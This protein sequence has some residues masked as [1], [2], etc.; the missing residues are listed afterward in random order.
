MPI[1]Y[2]VTYADNK[3]TIT[4]SCSSKSIS[5]PASLLHFQSKQQPHFIYNM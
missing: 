3:L 5:L 2:V 4:T 1:I